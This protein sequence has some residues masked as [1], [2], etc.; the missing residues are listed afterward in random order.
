MEEV[1]NVFGKQWEGR[2]GQAYQLPAKLHP[3]ST[4][5]PKKPTPQARRWVQHFLWTSTEQKV[6]QLTHLLPRCN[7]DMSE[8]C[9]RH[10]KQVCTEE[11]Q[12]P[13]PTGSRGTAGTL[14][15]CPLE[16]KRMGLQPVPELQPLMMAYRKGPIKRRYF[17][18]LF[19]S[20][21]AAIAIGTVSE[22]R[23]TKSHGTARKPVACWS[24]GWENH[25]LSV[26]HITRLN[27]D[28]VER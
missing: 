3:A 18:S 16:R 28:W 20:S 11:A 22:G 7:S 9:T 15:V 24:E 4:L 14:H 2:G 19:N 13:G 10:P 6:A 27:Q 21:S 23:V 26:H 5:S 12:A 25:K 8:G 1:Q 17:N